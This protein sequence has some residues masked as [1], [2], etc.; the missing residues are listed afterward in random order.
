M[1]LQRNN[2]HIE[3]RKQGVLGVVVASSWQFQAGLPEPREDY[4]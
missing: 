1:M 4:A 2:S 3:V